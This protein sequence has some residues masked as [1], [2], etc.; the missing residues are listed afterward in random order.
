MSGM[1]KWNMVVDIARCHDCNNCFLACKDEYV[2]NDFLPY[3]VAQPWHGH[4]WMN[5]LRAEGGQYPKVQVNYLP[6]PCQHCD[7]PACI[8]ADGAV[9]KRADGIVL[10]DPE[11]AAGRR[12]IV[13]SC[14]YGAIYW[15]EEKNVAQKCT[16][17]AHL[18]DAGWKEPRCAQVCPTGA[19]KAVLADDEE[20]A[21]LAAEEQLERYRAELGTKPRVYIKNLY[22]WN[23]AFLAGNIVFGDTDECAAGASVRISRSGQPVAETAADEFGDFMV[24]KL[25]TGDEYEVSV[26]AAGYQPASVPVKLRKSLNMGSVVLKK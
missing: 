11:K 14:A 12:E 22:R 3:S 24:E 20:M 18:M 2:G 9:Y 10:I 19:L 7:E 25:E 15:N 26:D 17:C 6:M 23:K 5:I 21:K 4:R 1:K 13:D 8:T 16:G